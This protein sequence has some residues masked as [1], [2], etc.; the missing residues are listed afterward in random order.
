M[1]KP[2][3]LD[4]IFR[5]IQRLPPNDAAARAALRVLPAL[6]EMVTAPMPV[7]PGCAF[8]GKVGGLS[9]MGLTCLI[10]Y[11]FRACQC[12]SIAKSG[13]D[14]VTSYADADLV[15]QVEAAYANIN[16]IG[17]APLWL[18]EPPPLPTR[19]PCP[20]HLMALP[21]TTPTTPLTMPAKPR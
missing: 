21:S 10:F 14:G 15:T 9:K 18:A 2:L 7:R 8:G 11:T 17:T 4:G 12:A 1:I 16:A 13:M 6:A 20:T 5:R 19:L 3:I